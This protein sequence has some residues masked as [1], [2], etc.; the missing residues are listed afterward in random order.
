MGILIVEADWLGGWIE[1][2][3]ILSGADSIAAC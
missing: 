1:I 3:A 2:A